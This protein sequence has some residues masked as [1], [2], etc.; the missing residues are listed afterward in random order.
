MSSATLIISS[1]PAFSFKGLNLD[2]SL[3]LNYKPSYKLPFIH[4]HFCNINNILGFAVSAE[5]WPFFAPQSQHCAAYQPQCSYQQTTDNAVSV[6][7]N[8]GNCF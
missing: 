6:E 7:A 2:Q 8:I 1:K 5:T 3:L 4:K